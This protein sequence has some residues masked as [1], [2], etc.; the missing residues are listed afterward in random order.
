VVEKGKERFAGDTAGAKTL[1]ELSFRLITEV[2][3]Q[4]YFR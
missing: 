4:E 1:A 2:F 3:R